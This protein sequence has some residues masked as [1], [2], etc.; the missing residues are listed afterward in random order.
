MLAEFALYG[1]FYITPIVCLEV[2]IPN[3]RAGLFLI[4]AGIAHLSAYD[5]PGYCV[6]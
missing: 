3:S 1:L 2:L 5:L 6:A 4:L